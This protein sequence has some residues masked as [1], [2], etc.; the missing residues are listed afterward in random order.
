MKKQIKWTLAAIAAASVSFAS[1]AQEE[2]ANNGESVGYTA[3][4]LGLATPVQLPWG[5]NWDV[6]GLDFNV[7]YADANKAYGADLAFGATQTRGDVRGLDLAGL[8]NLNRADV[9]GAKIALLNWTEGNTY[10]LGVDVVG[11]S[12]DFD[13]IALD[14]LGGWTKRNFNGLAVS[15]LGNF[16]GK[17][18]WGWQAALGANYADTVHGV[19]ASLVF[20]M[21]HSLKGAQ[22]GLVN[23]A[24]ECPGGFQI[25]LVNFIMD[26]VVPVFPILNFYLGF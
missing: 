3:L 10:G 7:F 20:N 17:D 6:F 16:A 23:F 18:L 11:I 2:T 24:Q 12:T 19:Q 22:I 21:T 26:N 14:V 15:G 25:G 13:G 5:F 4:A 8:F 9:Y 1:F